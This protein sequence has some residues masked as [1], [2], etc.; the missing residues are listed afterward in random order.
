MKKVLLLLADGFEM[1]EASAYID[2]IGWNLLEG[3]GDT[4]LFSA[5]GKRE[6]GS[7][8]SQRLRVDFTIDQ[9]D[10]EDFDALAVPGGFGEYGFYE[11]AYDEQFLSVI[12]AFHAKG[13][14]ISSV[15]TGAFPLAKSGILYGIE[16]TTYPLVPEF[17]NQLD[18]FGAMT[19]T[20]NIVVSGNIT[21]SS[22]PAMAIEVAFGL[23]SSLSGEENMK[24][25]RFLMGF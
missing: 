25:V 12:R 4:V 3:S 8:F 19:S 6:V 20:G 11:S 16:A 9:I 2:V 23:L 14:I 21:T 7:S 22:S 13:K 5:A 1:Y 10:P 17:P 15:C 18:D 24:S